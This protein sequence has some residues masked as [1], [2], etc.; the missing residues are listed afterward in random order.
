M[1]VLR[2]GRWPTTCVQPSAS[3]SSSSSVGG[4]A[5]SSSSSSVGGSASS[6]SSSSVGGSAGSSSSSSV[7]GSA[8]SSSSVGDTVINQGGGEVIGSKSND[9]HAGVTATAR[10]RAGAG[11]TVENDRRV[12]TVELIPGTLLR[13]ALSPSQSLNPS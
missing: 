2:E 6:S 10:A 11:R 4:S 3:S 5:S 8:S 13:Q 9:T 12:G 1:L 7:G